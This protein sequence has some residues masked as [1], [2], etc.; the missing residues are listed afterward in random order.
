MIIKTLVLGIGFASIITM[1]GCNK[2]GEMMP[3]KKENDTVKV[4]VQ[5]TPPLIAGQSVSSSMQVK[6][7]IV[8]NITKESVITNDNIIAGTAEATLRMA[9]DTL[10]FGN[11]KDAVQYFN[12]GNEPDLAKQLKNTQPAFQKTVDTITIQQVKYNDNKTEAEIQGIIKL[13][14]VEEPETSIYRLKKL[15]GHWKIETN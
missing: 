13:Y 2:T 1:T 8:N 9:L 12:V 14:N 15:D 11:A 5:K 4:K 6:S 10:Y 3:E 7:D